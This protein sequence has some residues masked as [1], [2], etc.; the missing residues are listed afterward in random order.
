MPVSSSSLNVTKASVGI[1]EKPSPF[2]VREQTRYSNNSEVSQYAHCEITNHR[3]LV[4]LATRNTQDPMYGRGST[5]TTTSPRTSPSYLSLHRN[6]IG[7]ASPTESGPTRSPGYDLR[8]TSARR[9]SHQESF[10]SQQSQRSPSV[11]VTG[12]LAEN[13]ENKSD[14][15]VA[16]RCYQAKT[17]TLKSCRR[18]EMSYTEKNTRLIEEIAPVATRG[19]S[20]RKCLGQVTQAQGPG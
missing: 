7:L 11:V 13:S 12:S 3:D 10:G 1:L 9:R 2:C 4:D 20:Q 14:K 15:T 5:V 16:L 17:E 8:E 19:D 6:N 18:Y